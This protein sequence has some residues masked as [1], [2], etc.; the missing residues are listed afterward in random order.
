MAKSKPKIQKRLAKIVMASLLLSGVLPGMMSPSV[1]EAGAAPVYGTVTKDGSS[2]SVE[3]TSGNTDGYGYGNVIF[4]K[5]TPRDYTVFE[6][7]LAKGYHSTLNLPE[8]SYLYAFDGARIF[9]GTVQDNTVSVEG[10]TLYDKVVGGSI[11]GGYYYTLDVLKHT[12]DNNQV[13]INGATVYGYVIGGGHAGAYYDEVAKKVSVTVS[14]NKVIINGGKVGKAIGGIAGDDYGFYT[15]VPNGKVTDNTVTIKAGTVGQAFGGMGY[16]VYE[17]NDDGLE[18]LDRKLISPTTVNKNEVHVE[19][20]SVTGSGGYAL[21]SRRVSRV[22]MGSV[23]GGVANGGDA[24]GNKVFISKEAQIDGMGS[25]FET[26]IVAGGIAIEGDA[27]KN[28][29]N[30]SGGNLGGISNSDAGGSFTIDGSPDSSDGGSVPAA[31]VFIAGGLSTKVAD[32]NI[33]TI[34]GG[35]ADGATIYGGAASFDE[36]SSGSGNTVTISGKDTSIEN[37]V[38]IGGGLYLNSYGVAVALS[39]DASEPVMPVIKADNNKVNVLT[40]A[41]PLAIFG[42]LAGF[43]VE[44]Y[45]IKSGTGNTL[46]VA[47]KGVTAYTVGGFQNMNFYLPKDIKKNDT[48]I[49]IKTHANSEEMEKSFGQTNRAVL[50]AFYV[51]KY[52]MKTIMEKTQQIR[53][54]GEETDQ[55]TI[56]AILKETV[57]PTDLKGVT[58]GVAA[59]QG[60]N[61]KKGDKVTLITDENGLTTES[62]LKTKDSK[63]LGKETFLQQNSMTTEEKYELS[64][65]KEGKN[66]IVTTVDDIIENETDPDARKSPVE[67]RIGVMN[68]INNAGDMLA[69]QG[70]SNAAAAAAGKSDGAGFNSF[71]AVNYGQIR[72]ESGSHVTNKGIGLN[73]GFARE[74][75]NKS[76]KL[77]FG[78]VVEYGHGSYDSYQDNGMKADGKASYW[79]LGFIAKQTNN[80]GFYYEG[81]LRVGRTKSDYGSN[82]I[83]ENSHISYDSSATYWAAHLGAG[84]LK[85]IGHNNTLDYYGKYFYS[86]TGSDSTTIYRDGEDFDRVNFDGVNSNRIRVGARVTHALNERNKIY[87]GLAYQYEFSGEARATYRQG[88]APSPSM[89]GSSGMIELGWQVKP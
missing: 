60:V 29:V 18:G 14:N 42:G 19:G 7:T 57:K 12:V 20:G 75:E 17:E 26:G 51:N 84:M 39:D 4:E 62:K 83:V 32:D 21:T 43:D 33:V 45:S 30:I 16:G 3:I 2:K 87:G 79:G 82:S 10:G 77:L 46:N 61:L 34:S 76:G 67:T 38:I 68:M 24:T 50:Q 55:E 15:A 70:M 86:H 8:T 22:I 78:P 71:A 74:L 11:G 37:A 88:S 6:Q 54:A 59:L 1:A 5:N 35:K 81:S 13:E 89:K 40:E 72:G 41:H 27:K 52:D 44:N 36:G 25:R 69:G 48:M 65:K 85:D 47:A 28:E 66:S 49:T 56:D 23:V 9:G 80:S 31:P 53:E 64:I 63:E 73:L 58:F